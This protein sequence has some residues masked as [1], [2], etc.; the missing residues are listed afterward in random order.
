MLKV[1]KADA[2]KSSISATGFWAGMTVGRAG[3]GFITDKVGE[4][5]SV[6]IYLTIA[7]VLELIFWLVPTFVVSAVAVALLGVFIGEW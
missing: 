7:L 4:R 5:L 6:I 1:R 2:Y 3:L